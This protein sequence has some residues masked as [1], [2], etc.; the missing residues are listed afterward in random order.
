M[1]ESGK[2]RFK[3]LTV[4]I[5]YHDPCHLGRHTEVY[6]PPR[7]ILRAVPGVALVEM[8][9]SRELS[10]CCGGGAGVK[11]AYPEVSRK[12]ALRRIKEAEETGAEALVTTCPFCVQTLRAAAE[13]SGSRM[14]VV[15]LS[16]FLD[17]LAVPSGVE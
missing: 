9:N 3:G 2:I 13:S 7:A 15:E 14:R 10:R 5:T 16:V 4:K 8:T 17:G 6:E 1:V 11:T 12:V